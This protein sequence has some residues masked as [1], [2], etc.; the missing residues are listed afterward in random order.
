[1]FVCFSVWNLGK[2][3]YDW[4]TTNDVIQF[5]PDNPNNVKKYRPLSLIGIVDKVMVLKYGVDHVGD[6]CLSNIKDL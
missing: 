3:S 5:K 6:S 1:L 4:N 2:Y